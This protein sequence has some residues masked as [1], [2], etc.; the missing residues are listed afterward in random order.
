MFG[1]FRPFPG[2][3]VAPIGVATTS[4][5]FSNSTD[6]A[7]NSVCYLS[8]A[9]TFTFAFWFKSGNTSAT[10]SYVSLDTDGGPQIAIIYGYASSG[11]NAQLE[12][13]TTVGGSLN[14]RTG[15]QITISDTN[16]H[17]IAYRYNGTSWDYFLDG[18]KTVI[19]GAL[20]GTLPSIAG[21]GCSFSIGV[22]SATPAMSVARYYISS[23][24]LTDMQIATMAGATCSTSG[25]SGTLFYALLGTASPDPE[26]AP[27]PN[28]NSLTI[29]GPTVSTGPS[30][31]GT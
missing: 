24:A 1:Q 27:S 9:T 3:G 17:H 22:S 14:F 16:W 28:T 19:D 30:C 20:S 11:G 6:T 23:A 5:L 8:G 31:S 2:P 29:S 4:R 13:F 25:V 15:S 18:V 7:S 26:H 12:F 10:N 21:G